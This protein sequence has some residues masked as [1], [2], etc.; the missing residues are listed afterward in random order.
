M[1]KRRFL[2]DLNHC[3]GRDMITSHTTMQ[4]AAVGMES[5][6]LGHALF[7]SGKLS[8]AIHG[9]QLSSNS[10]PVL[11]TRFLFLGCQCKLGLKEAQFRDF[12]WP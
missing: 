2:L 5:C 11:P 4:A 12:W 10:G 9:E 1:H 7:S 3:N 6:C 8:I